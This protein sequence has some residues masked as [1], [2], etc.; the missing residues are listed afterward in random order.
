MRLVL[1]G[2]PQMSL[3]LCAALGKCMPPASGSTRTV[4]GGG[5]AVRS[6]GVS[7]AAESSLAD[8][9]A[10][11]RLSGGTC[12]VPILMAAQSVKAAL[13]RKE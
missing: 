2:D 12:L 6:R 13:D 10:Q 9:S 7:R 4:D 1:L 11:R 3:P 5:S 8:S